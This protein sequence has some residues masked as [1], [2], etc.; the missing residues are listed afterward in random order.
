MQLARALNRRKIP[1]LLTVQID[2]VG[3]AD[4]TIPSNVRAAANIFQHDPLSIRGQSRIH[5]EDPS[6]TRILENTRHSYFFR[7]VESLR[8]EDANW[9]RRTLGGSHAKM[10]LDPILWRHV[11]EMILRAINGTL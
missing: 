11:E 6:A 10:E 9:A 1:V 7:P 3:I 2:S 8:A 4:A 5:A